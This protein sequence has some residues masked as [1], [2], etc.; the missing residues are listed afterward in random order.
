MWDDVSAS[1]L[2]HETGNSI[3]NVLSNYDNSGLDNFLTMLLMIIVLSSFLSKFANFVVR[4]FVEIV[5]FLSDEHERKMKEEK[6]MMWWVFVAE[7]GSN[8][9]IWNYFCFW[10]K[11]P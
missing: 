1:L 7:V 9:D 8:R 11:L 4:H 10:V 3:S 5:P 6:Y 2:G